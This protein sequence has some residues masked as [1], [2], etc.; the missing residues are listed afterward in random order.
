MYDKFPI[1]P[2]HHGRCFANWKKVVIWPRVT[3]TR[4]YNMLYE[5]SRN[6]G[7]VDNIAE[8]AEERG[9]AKAL[10]SEMNEPEIDLYEAEV[11]SKSDRR[12]NDSSVINATLPEWQLMSPTA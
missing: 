2:F 7:T 3:P 10:P 1:S 4:L 6:R 8:W 11:S 5:F 9:E 12:L